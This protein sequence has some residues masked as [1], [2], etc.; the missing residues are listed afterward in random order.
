[1][2]DTLES[3]EIEIKHSATGAAGEISKVADAIS[4]LSKALNRSLISK[5]V[6]LANAMKELGGVGSPINL[7]SYTGNTF[8]KTVQ[9][10]R[11]AAAS[12]AVTEES[13]P[14]DD[15][16]QE[17]IENATKL[18]IAIHKAADA[19]ERMQK[20]FESGNETAAWR[21]REQAINA[22][23][24][25]A[26]EYEKANP[27]PKETVPPVSAE[28]QE[29]IKSASEIDVLKAKLVS[30]KTAM[31]EAFEAGNADKAYSIR[32]QIISTEKALERA[33]SAAHKTAS[34]VRHLSKEAQKCKL[35]L[36]SLIRSLKQL[37][38]SSA[39]KSKSVLGNLASSLK[40]IAYYRMIR[41]IIKAITKAFSDG[42]QYA[43]AFSNGIEGTGHRFAEAMDTIKSSSTQMKAQLGSAFIGLLAALTPII[44]AIINLI[45]KLSDALSQLFAA[46]TGGT[47]LK[48][49]KV[50]EK[51][52]DDMKKGAG[53][54]KEW[55]NQLLGFDELNR[56]NEPSNGGGGGGASTDYGKF[57]EENIDS[58]IMDFVQSLKQGIAQGDWA[59]VGKLI[60]EKI[61]S[62]FP[63]KAKWAEWGKKLGSSFRNVLVALRSAI[64][65]AAFTKFGERVASGINAALEA[66]L[67]TD[68][69]GSA[70]QNLGILLV[71]RF[72]KALDFAIGFIKTLDWGLLGKQ[73]GDCFR[74][75]ILYTG[76]WIDSKDWEEIGNGLVTSLGD[77]LSGLD[78]NSITESFLNLVSRIDFKK[79]GET[80]AELINKVFE[81]IDLSTVGELLV[82][83]FTIQIDFLIGALG[84][85]DW[86]GITSSLGDLLVGALNGITEWIETVDWQGVGSQV[87]TKLIELIEG[88]DFAALATSFFTFLGTAMRAGMELTQ[89]IFVGVFS[90][91]SDYFSEKTEEA[92][93][94]AWEGFKKGIEDGV[95]NIGNWAMDNVITPFLTALFGD[96]AG[97]WMSEKVKTFFGD[98]WNS[99]GQ[100]NSIS[101]GGIVGFIVHNWETIKEKTTSVFNFVKEKISGVLNKVKE[102]VEEV[103]GFVKQFFTEK[104]DAVK[105]KAEEVHDAIH[106]F[107]VRGFESARDSI[108]GVLDSLSTWFSET[109][110]GLIGW[111]QSAHDWLQDVLEGLGLVGGK[112]DAIGG[113]KMNLPTRA[114]GGFVDD[115]QLFIANEAGP[116]LVGTM[117]GRTAVGN[118]DQIVE[119]IRQGVFEAVSAAM[120]N[121][122]NGNGTEFKLFLDSREIKFGL[123]RLDRAWG[124]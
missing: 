111:C 10:M 114:N 89:G 109:F 102:K 91:L 105:L 50:S 103:L 32:S 90:S 101:L 18:E 115:G 37:S 26:R 35:P 98:L 64:S 58:E 6:D 20:A 118:N 81:N 94:N 120:S 16:L 40:R 24:Q 88:I 21:A 93:G 28:L 15:G 61:N 8:N 5:L 99:I 11:Q 60:G 12:K 44:T 59:G 49:E 27:A 29:A 22:A 70:A 92:G 67:G 4:G 1:M 121:G 36:K 30:L 48:A 47:Y 104:I 83:F 39:P 25:A 14:L 106:D 57:A 95:A 43:Y 56:L 7:N 78:I 110:G 17:K 97:T 33:E 2:A 73:I 19:G 46:F 85:L 82:K 80:V 123:E 76:S 77:F 72:T 34:G 65:I 116:E 42:L 63:T 87:F 71:M 84:T 113:I 117:N 31:Q 100:I 96:E 23:A 69:N 41:G 122:N 107:L 74:T 3:L 53:G 62:I 45:I 112:T 54:A 13:T 108:K 68:G 119:G 75:A 86:G 38:S 51:F 124:A 79:I 66:S 55:K 9:T 52:A